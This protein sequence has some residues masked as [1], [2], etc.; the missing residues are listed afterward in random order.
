MTII[1]WPYSRKMNFWRDSW[2]PTVKIFQGWCHET[3]STYAEALSPM[4]DKC[5]K[6]CSFSRS[7]VNASHLGCRR[8]KIL[9]APGLFEV[10]VLFRL[11][12]PSS[13]SKYNIAQFPLSFRYFGCARCVGINV[14][15]TRWRFILATYN[16]QVRF[17]CAITVNL[18][19]QG[20]LVAT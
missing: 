18:R 13:K 14:S 1:S 7:V 3:T 19:D 20:R 16:A 5:S 4:E 17:T 12:F 10:Q 6:R 2:L 8:L 15:P 9:S 11:I